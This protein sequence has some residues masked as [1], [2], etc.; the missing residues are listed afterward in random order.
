MKKFFGRLVSMEPRRG[1]IV[2]LIAL[3][4]VSVFL[5]IFSFT[6][7]AGG[8][9]GGAGRENSDPDMP[10]GL[11]LNIDKLD[12]LRS[13]EQQ[14]A[15]VRGWEPGKTFNPL[16]RLRAIEKMEQSVAERFQDAILAPEINGASW[17][18]IGPAPIPK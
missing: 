17:T 15:L 10:E 16:A 18:A 5:L 12:Y 14:I 6:P 9:G 1:R 13:R 7:L 11:G 2:I 3:V 8:A 4:S